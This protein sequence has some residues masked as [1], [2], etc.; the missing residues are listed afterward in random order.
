MIAIGRSHGK[1]LI[2]CAA[3]NIRPKAI[4]ISPLFVST[5]IKCFI[6][7]DEDSIPR[8]VK[9]EEVARCK[10]LALNKIT[11]IDP[12]GKERLWEAAKRT[13]TCDTGC[14]AVCVIAVLK[15]LLK[16]DSLVLVKQY[17]P[18]MR[19]YT[20][21]MPAGLMDKK[22]TPEQTAVRELK[23]ETGYT[24]T[25][26]HISPITCMDAGTENVTL[27]M[28]TAEIDGDT[29]DNKN[30]KP[31]PEESECIEVVH[32]PMNDLIGKL[33]EFAKSGVVVDS[34]L[35]SY[36]IGLEMTKDNTQSPSVHT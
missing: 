13:T 25:P 24:A 35:Y 11:Y 12:R 2:R 34:R 27:Q 32:V 8:F 20:L 28:V 30:P 17:R 18:P 15:R 21:E 36:A 29:D 7:M 26:K 10:W 33:N 22:E 6:R 16:F 14:D 5:S 9:E 31:N 3:I 1:S 4:D 19:A 23:E